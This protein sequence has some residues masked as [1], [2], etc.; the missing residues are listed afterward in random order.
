MSERLSAHAL[1]GIRQRD[2]AVRDSDLTQTSRDRRELL[3]ELDR[4][5]QSA[6]I[7]QPLKWYEIVGAWRCDTACGRYLTD[8]RRW[9]GPC[10]TRGS[11]CESI[12][13]GMRLCWE[14]YQRR[15]AELFCKTGAVE[16]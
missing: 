13:H 6:D 7:L 12:E 2:A 1:G 10:A 4:R 9:W 11:D 15:V 14:D 16:T 3:R 5:Q 8:D